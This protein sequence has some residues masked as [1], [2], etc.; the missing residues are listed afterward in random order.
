MII[1]LEYFLLKYL[2]LLKINGISLN[3][4]QQRWKIIKAFRSGIFSGPFWEGLPHPNEFLG[5][6]GALFQNN[7][8]DF[9]QNIGA[10]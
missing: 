1:A 10:F 9:P 7:F 2:V 5:K 6:N 3:F 8:G 4:D